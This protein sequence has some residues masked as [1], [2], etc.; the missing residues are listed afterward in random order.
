MYSFFSVFPVKKT[1]FAK[2]KG[3]LP[4]CVKKTSLALLLLTASWYSD[5]P[6]FTTI[7]II[8]ICGTTVSAVKSTFQ[9][10][11]AA[12]KTATFRTTVNAAFNFFHL[13]PG[14]CFSGTSA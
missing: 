5:T 10:N 12:M 8:A 14:K 13:C 11:T 2:Q 4:S 9:V 1:V 6:W 3:R 7:S